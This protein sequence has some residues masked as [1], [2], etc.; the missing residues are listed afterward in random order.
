ML[1]MINIECNPQLEICG[2]SGIVNI[3]LQTFD[4]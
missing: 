2:L 4:L 1:A 3:L